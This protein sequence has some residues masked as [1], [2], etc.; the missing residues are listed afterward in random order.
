MWRKLCS[1]MEYLNTTARIQKALKMGKKQDIG[2]IRKPD[3]SYKDLP[4]ETLQVLLDTH[5]PDKDETEVIPQERLPTGNLNI[6]GM[7]N[8]QT[9]RAAFRSFKPYKAP[10]TDGIFPILIQKGM[11][12]IVNKLVNIFRKGLRE[13]KSPK[14]WLESKVVFIPKPG[15]LDYGDPKSLRPLSLT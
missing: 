2:T 10:G 3:G 9:V 4:E 11:D 7:V 6:E 12:V 13:G 8:E 5:F 1:E 15:K 14:R